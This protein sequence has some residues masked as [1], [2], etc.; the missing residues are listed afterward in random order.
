M[1]VCHI[2]PFFYPHKL[3]GVEKWIFSLSQF[4]SKSTQDMCFLLLTDRSNFS[5]YAVSAKKSQYG[6]LRVYRLGPHL[7]S[8]IYYSS[9]IKWQIIEKLSLLQ[10]FD[11]ANNL[12]QIKDVDIFHLHGV[13]L[14]KEYKQYM[15]LALLLSRFFNKPLVVS[16]HNDIVGKYKE[17]GMPLFKSEIRK[18][19][20]HAKA[21][22]T[23]SPSILDILS[24]LGIG[25]KSYLI[26]NFVDTESFTCPSPRDYRS[27]TR[28]IFV[29][30]LDPERDPLTVI[31]A[32]K[33]VKEKI[34]NS[35]LT[36][37]GNGSMYK[38]LQDF[39]HR[40]KLDN[41]I[42]LKGQHFDV[43][44]FLWDSDI[45][46]GVGY[47]TLLEAWA[48]GLPVVVYNWGILGQLASHRKNAILVRPHNPGELARALVELMENEQLRKKL[49]LNGMKTV[50]NHD[51]R[52]VAPKIGNIYCT[53]LKTINC[54]FCTMR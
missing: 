19:L 45:F 46:I 52:S 54:R 22:T 3:G 43:R 39:V 37:V 48:A 53:V 1:I 34:P 28:V 14:R 4:L 16:L 23:Y 8:A 18:I 42:I 44:S 35:T 7:F 41:D 2:Y 13:W 38:E 31:K 11:E 5:C 9:R 25:S 47:L 21:I 29:S 6:S 20:A 40:L 27:A 51:I 24:K 17:A 32:F 33:Y 36:V 15:D 10:L 49:A 50:K 30:R 26:P 12:P